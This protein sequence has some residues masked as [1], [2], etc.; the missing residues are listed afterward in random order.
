MLEWLTRCLPGFSII[1]L[2]LLLTLAFSDLLRWQVWTGVFPP[3]MDQPFHSG[4]WSGL[5]L[6]QSVFVAY[7]VLIHV[8]MFGFTCRLG[9]TMFRVTAKVKETALRRPKPSPL[10]SP[11]S[12]ASDEG[13]VSQQLS[14]IS[15]PSPSPLNE[16]INH[17]MLDE[18]DDINREEL[19]HAIILPNYCEDLHTLE[20]TLKVLECHPRAQ[21]QYEVRVNYTFKFVL[22]LNWN[23]YI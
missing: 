14:P 10:S 22:V 15:L 18:M 1:G 7:S 8:Q 13:Y 2:G 3:W 20:T 16:K 21:S 19:I 11:S 5:N 9:W 4:W 23:R 17:V 6:A 12:R